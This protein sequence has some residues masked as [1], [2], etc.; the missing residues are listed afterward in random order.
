MPTNL[1]ALIRYKQIDRELRSPL[2]K[3]TIKSLQESCSNQLAEHRG[4]Y[5]LISERTIRDDIRV[6]RSSALG[7]NAPIVVKDSFYSYK[8][9]SFSIFDSKIEHMELLQSVAM[10]LILERDNIKHPELDGIIEALSKVIDL[11]DSLNNKHAANED[12]KQ[13][14]EPTENS[15]FCSMDDS[16]EGANDSSYLFALE[17]S[18]FRNDIKSYTA[19]SS[20][21]KSPKSKWFNFFKKKKKPTPLVVESEITYSWNDILKLL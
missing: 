5:K 1:N 21:N 2:L 19:N 3:T 17:D 13:G 14:I 10:L 16:F 9:P 20:E 6:M 18:E 15:S 11:D 4:V 8:D 12:I 7:F